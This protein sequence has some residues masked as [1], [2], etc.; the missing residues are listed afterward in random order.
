MSLT[1]NTS[2]VGWSHGL[3]IAETQV[4]GLIATAES[5]IARLT[6]QIRELSRLRAKER[7]VLATLR[8]MI[9]PIGKL[10]T[11][12]LVEIFSLAVHTP[13]LRDMFVR[14]AF[15]GWPRSLYQGDSR[16]ALRKVL[17]LSQVSSYWRQIIC[18]TPRLWSEGVVDIRL[19]RE[20][21]DSY[22][23]GLET[24]FARSAPYP[25]SLSLDHGGKKSSATAA[26]A[27]IIVPTVQRWRNFDTDLDSFLHFGDFPPGTFQALERLHI[28]GLSE[29]TTS[30]SIMAFQ[31]SPRL[32]SFTLNN[33]SAKIHLFHLP[34]GQLTHLDI[35]DESL[36]GCRNV[37]LQ[38]SNL[39][40]AKISTSVEWDLTTEAA[41]SPIVV[42]PFLTTLV[43]N[44]E[45]GSD[46]EPV[47]G[48]EAF[49][50]P[51]ALP[52]LKTI[53]FQ[54][55]SETDE[56]WPTAV[57]SEFQNR[58]PEIEEIT[59][60][61]SSIYAD[62]LVS[63]LRHAP[64]LTTLRLECCWNSV[65]EDLFY[66]LRY[67]DSDLTPVAPKLQD[68]HLEHVSLGDFSAGPFEDAVRSRWWKDGERL[69]ADGS[70]PR[71][72]R[73]K[74]LL[75]CLEESEQNDDVKARVQDLIDQGLDW[76]YE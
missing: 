15:S 50:S 52:S 62:E 31:S 44:F 6:E 46:S 64:A 5:N 14:S 10:P 37:L 48:L 19:N 27:N 4:K 66:A 56:F 40:F 13:V 69:L 75:L 17:C 73:L 72:C 8:L 53:D 70:P 58:S 23:S 29:L 30:R 45:F 55:D 59:M 47:G 2:T 63:L 57:F 9:V 25:I 74:K 43:V 24:M 67:D 60:I 71:V 34:W 3:A 36:G 49:F 16:A 65:D 54:F 1:L 26:I 38:C 76:S 68:I 35:S 41:N 42:L 33:L 22:L 39:I 20:L 28:K 11:E 7:S 61:F 51:L 18:D 21:T 32:R 12:V